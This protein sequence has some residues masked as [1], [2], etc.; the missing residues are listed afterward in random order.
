MRNELEFLQLSD[1][2]L[3]R[4]L[5]SLLQDSRHT[6][7]ELVAHIGEVDARRLY[8]REA[9]PSMHV[10]CMKVLQLSEAEAYLR[11][12][13]GRL[14]REFPSIL[15][16]LADGRLHLSAISRLAPHLT[17]QNHADLLAR[18]T[19]KSRRQVEELVAELAPRPDVP[20]VIR[21]LPTR[22]VPEGPPSALAPQATT[23]SFDSAPQLCPDRVG[24]SSTSSLPPAQV[25]VLAPARYKVQF[26]AGASFRDKLERLQALMRSRFPNGDLAQILEDA[27]TEKLERLE[28]RRFAKTALPRSNQV[29]RDA[30]SRY[31]PVALRRAVNVRD[32]NR[33]RFVDAQ[34]RRCP[35]RHDLEYHHRVPFGVGGARTLA[36][37]CL[38]C[39]AHNQ[40]LA[41]RDYGK[42]TMDRY[43][44][45]SKDAGASVP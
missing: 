40:Y 35:E 19:Y 36:N 23:A 11:I 42:A 26:T 1:D 33:C 38:M 25:E 2:D 9:Y 34:G 32:E 41:D 12:T 8:A 3:L 6:E 14:A 5:R 16:M 22:A 43:R 44:S 20:D 28:A 7:S 18:A 45:A 17:P 27:V 39:R 29:P 24:S 10:Y 4:R 30:R 21:K 15:E 31:L 37:V 13:A